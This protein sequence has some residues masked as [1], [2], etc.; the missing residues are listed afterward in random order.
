MLSALISTAIY[1]LIGWILIDR[2]PMRKKMT[3][4]YLFRRTKDRLEEGD[5]YRYFVYKYIW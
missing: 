2:L 5:N 1:C 3:K 4:K